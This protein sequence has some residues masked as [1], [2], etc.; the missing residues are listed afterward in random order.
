[1]NAEI[2]SDLI[3]LVE[4]SKIV[5]VSSIDEDQYPNTKCMFA[6]KNESLKTHYF[7]TNLSAKRTQQFL[8]NP[9]ACVY[10]CD[11]PDFKGL[12]LIGVIE[13]CRDRSSRKMLWQDGFELYYPE[14]IDDEDYCVLKFSAQKGNYYNRLINHSFLVD[15]LEYGKG[16]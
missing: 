15:E 3:N 9:K 4:S 12:M 1:M 5:F 7:S 13:V 10:F 2:K 6:L 11:E 16:Q 8:S 14:G